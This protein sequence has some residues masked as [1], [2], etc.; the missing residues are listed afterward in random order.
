[1]NYVSGYI[2][3]NIQQLYILE[4]IKNRSKRRNFDFANLRC[5]FFVIAHFRTNVQ[6]FC[7]FFMNILLLYKISTPIGAVCNHI[8]NRRIRNCR[9]A[10]IFSQLN[11]IILI[12]RNIQNVVSENIE[13]QESQFFNI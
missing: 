5:G 1:M 4:Y 13:L 8:H 12:R 10:S 9:Y 6:R 2:I 7:Q 11:T 3:H